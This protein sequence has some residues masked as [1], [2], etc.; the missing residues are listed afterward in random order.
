MKNILFRLPIL[1]VAVL[2]FPFSGYSQENTDFDLTYEVNVVH[3]PL[4]ISKGQLTAAKTLQDLNRHYK[5]SWVKSYKSVEI[6]ASHQGEIKK[7]VSHDGQLTVEQKDFMDKAD[8][9]TNISIRI[10]YLPDNNLKNNE[11]KRN[12]FSFKIVPEQEAQFVGGPETLSQY[13]K[14]R[15]IDKLPKG[16]IKQYALTAVKFTVDTDGKIIN[17]HVFE[18]SKDEEIDTL[19]VSTIS[20]MPNWKPAEYANGLKVKQDFV[21]TVGDMRSCVVNL[22]NINQIK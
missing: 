6:L 2:A 20:N 22:L 12:N 1:F 5:S 18:S 17:T 4:A 3:P 14:E 9:D 10:L 11:L 8:E 21:F 7:I 19:L 15:A 13:L 16:C